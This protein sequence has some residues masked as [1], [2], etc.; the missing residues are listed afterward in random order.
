MIILSLSK[1]IQEYSRCTILTYG[2][3][4]LLYCMVC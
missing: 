2:Q 4:I 3:I 1:Y